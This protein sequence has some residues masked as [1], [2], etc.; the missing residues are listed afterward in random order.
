MKSFRKSCILPCCIAF[1][2]I[3]VLSVRQASAETYQYDSTGRLTSVT[4]D[5]GSSITY[6][7]DSA[8]NLLQNESSGSADST[9]TDSG[10]GGCFIT[11]TAHGP[12][13]ANEVSILKSF[14]DN[15]LLALSTG[16]NLVKL[17]YNVSP[18]AFFNTVKPSSDYIK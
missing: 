4:Y 14:R 17:Y 13:V 15:V 5:D 6:T 11:T 18:P 8:G 2:I 9:G 1:V 16:R 12:R 7:Y 10:G 3:L